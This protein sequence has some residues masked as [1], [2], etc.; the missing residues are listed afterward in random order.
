MSDVSV[1]DILGDDLAGILASDRVADVLPKRL[2]VRLDWR[3]NWKLTY[4]TFCEN[5]HF[6]DLHKNSFGDP[7]PV[8]NDLMVADR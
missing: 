2:D 8:V 1:H 7:G 4:E 6:I 3:C 5:Y